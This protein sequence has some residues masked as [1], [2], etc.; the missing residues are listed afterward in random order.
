[1]DCLGR[2]IRTPHVP[3]C[4]CLPWI[5]DA[6]VKRHLYAVM[7][8]LISNPSLKLTENLQIQFAKC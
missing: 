4:S 3:V 1:M 6:S 8:I 7:T 2:F 5:L